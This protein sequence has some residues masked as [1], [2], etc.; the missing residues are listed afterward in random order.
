MLAPQTAYEAPIQV[1]PKCQGKEKAL[2]KKK[3][4]REENMPVLL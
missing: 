4:V 1:R 3:E 2:D